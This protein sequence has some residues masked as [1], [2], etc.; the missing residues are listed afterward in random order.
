MW[1]R[2]SIRLLEALREPER[3]PGGEDLV[4]RFRRVAVL[5]DVDELGV[6]AGDA[7]FDVAGSRAACSARARPRRGCPGAAG[8]GTI[9][10]RP[11]GSRPRGRSPRLRGKPRGRGLREALGCDRRSAWRHYDITMMSLSSRIDSRTTATRSEAGRYMPICRAF[12]V[13][14]AGVSRVRP[15]LRNRERATL[16][17]PPRSARAASSGSPSL[18][19]AG[20]SGR[21]QTG[22][23]S[24]SGARP[25]TGH[26]GRTSCPR[27]G[28]CSSRR[29]ASADG[30]RPAMLRS[31]AD[32][33]SGRGA[34][35]PALKSACARRRTAAADGRG[36]RS[37]SASWP[38]VRGS[39]RRS[40][41]LMLRASRLRA[42]FAAATVGSTRPFPP[43]AVATADGIPASAKRSPQA[44]IERRIRTPPVSFASR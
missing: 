28:E 16:A 41:S 38:P 36:R 34:A 7:D 9:R 33:R 11:R 29:G 40:S 43:A 13:D 2:T 3:D 26:P 8:R 32:A 42:Y 23:S 19:A 30:A 24:P 27:S 25:S 12:L 14:A 39:L 6:A 1:R 22:R 21:T 35:R 31:H 15:R 4:D 37:A 17:R 18:C 44:K 5:A 20:A 10:S